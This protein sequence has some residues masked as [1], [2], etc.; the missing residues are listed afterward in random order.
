MTKV[1]SAQ[2]ATRLEDIPN[3]G[4]SIANDLRH[5]GIHSP[6]DVKEMEPLQVFDL[7]RTPM[8]RR[9]DP[10]VLDVFLAAKDFINGGPP[11]PRWAYSA[12]RKQ[13]L[14]SINL[15]QEQ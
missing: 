12:R 5:V 11:Q 9:H 10:C 13:L 1:S 4:K 6:S 2:S 7:L 8:G 15:V 3:I 14:A